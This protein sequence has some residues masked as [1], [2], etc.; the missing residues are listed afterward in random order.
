MQRLFEAIKQGHADKIGAG[1]LQ[2]KE[3]LPGAVGQVRGEVM[4]ERPL[5]FLGDRVVQGAGEGP[6]DGQ[7]RR[8]LQI[9]H[10]AFQV[11]LVVVVKANIRKCLNDLLPAVIHAVGL[12]D[13][14]NDHVAVGSFI[15]DDFRMAG[16]DH[17]GALLRSY[18][19]EELVN[20]ALAQNLEVGV[21]LVQQEDR[22]GIG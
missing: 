9:K 21:G 13:K 6:Q 14:G 7:V 16:R 20:L 17:L 22:F 19:R 2:G 1:F 10:P 5:Q 12:S 18:V 4:G 3:M 15:E 11:S 8:A